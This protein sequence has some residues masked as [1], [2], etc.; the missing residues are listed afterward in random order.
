MQES[1]VRFQRIGEAMKKYLA[2]SLP[3]LFLLACPGLVR[4]HNDPIPPLDGYYTGSK[5]FANDS[6]CAVCHDGGLN[7]SNGNVKLSFNGSSTA[8]TYAPG[9]T[10]PIQV[11]ITDTG[12]GRRVWG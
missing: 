8:T 4:A 6:F 5:I 12:G 11:T 1:A 3:V 2:I 10:I 9:A 7:P